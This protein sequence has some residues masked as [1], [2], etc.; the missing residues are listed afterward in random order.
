MA[1]S[2]T[3][4]WHQGHLTL[5]MSLRVP[6]ILSAVLIFTENIPTDLRTD[7]IKPYIFKYDIV[8][9][10]NIKPIGGRN[11]AKHPHSWIAAVILRNRKCS[12]RRI[13]TPLHRETAVAKYDVFGPKAIATRHRT[14]KPA[15]GRLVHCHSFESH[16]AQTRQSSV[17][18][19]YRHRFTSRRRVASVETD[20]DRHHDSALHPDIRKDNIFRKST[21][22]DIY[23]QSCRTCMRCGQSKLFR[24]R[25]ALSHRSAAI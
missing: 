4:L 18:V 2:S 12:Q 25:Y 16:I 19:A 24:I 21:V 5:L 10:P 9:M 8:R 1:R 6:R 14:R 20:A 15:G 22:D 23:R 13:R 7:R 17:L 3:A 11:G